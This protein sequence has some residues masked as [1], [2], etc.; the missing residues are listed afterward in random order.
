LN[1]GNI[2]FSAGNSITLGSSNFTGLPTT[3]SGLAGA[4]NGT[5]YYCSDCQQ[6]NPCNSGGN[7]AI[8][9]RINSVWVC[10]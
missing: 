7:G 9:K 4:A 6:T 10:N 3:A 8:A 5:L 1:G 2:N